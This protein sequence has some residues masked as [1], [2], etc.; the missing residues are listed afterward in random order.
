MKD[1]ELRGLRR[2]I[3]ELEKE[4]E[5][6]KRAHSVTPDESL[7]A[8]H[9]VET[10]REPL[11]VL[12]TS[13]RV[14]SV[15][16]AFCRTFQTDSRQTDGKLVYELGDNQWDI[17]KL[18]RLLEEI[19]PEN[20][21]FEDFEVDHEFPEIGRKTVVLNARRI[22]DAQMILLA[23]EDV[24]ERKKAEDALKLERNGL[25]DTVEQRTADLEHAVSDLEKSNVK[26]DGYAHTVSHDLRGS[27]ARIEGATVSLQNLLRSPEIE[28]L[29]PRIDEMVDIIN[30]GV[31]KATA[32]IDDLLSLAEAGQAPTGEVVEVDV[33]AVV[34]RIQQEA[35]E[36]IKEKGAEV[37]VDDELGKLEAS[38]THIYQLFSNL[39]VNA[40]I[41]NDNQ[42]PVVEVNYL[43]PDGAGGHRYLVR[44]N[45]S[46][47]PEEDLNRVFIPFFKGESGQTGIGLAIVAQIVNTYGGIV[48]AYNDN[49]ACFEFT[50]SDFAEA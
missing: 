32:L 2:R 48:K 28:D 12:D 22:D 11:M 33:R 31:E 25:E 10:V 20:S 43:G 19:L 5:E 24:T 9:I 29:H 13:L 47:I 14:L 21:T 8:K 49:G 7:F 41:H 36:K 40:V 35:L 45:G 23:F 16:P 44:D 42:N 34:E 1:A 46:G 39:I 3:S 38:P 6:F 37:E 26:L 4:L 27:L 18:R 15:N 30:E 17:P 50:I